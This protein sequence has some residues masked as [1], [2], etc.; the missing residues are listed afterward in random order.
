MSTEL[1]ATLADHA[2]GSYRVLMNMAD[3]LLAVAADRELARLDE[4]LFLD[5]FAHEPRP[6]AAARQE[7][8]KQPS[9]REL[10]ALPELAL[11]PALLAAIDGLLASLHAQ[12]GTPR[13]DRLPADPRTLREARALADEL[14][15]ARR[16]LRRYVCAV[17]RTLRQPVRHDDQL[18]F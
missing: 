1:K 5:V 6:K 14:H 3:E 8:M 10:W 16:A 15:T 9:V 18:P 4:K 11:I 13:E 17:R 7:A 12:H 2:A